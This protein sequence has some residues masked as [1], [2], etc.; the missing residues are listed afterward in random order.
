MHIRKMLFRNTLLFILCSVLCLSLFG[1]EKSYDDKVKD[2]FYKCDS[3]GQFNAITIEFG[4]DI[5]GVY[6]IDGNYGVI[7]DHG[8][9]YL[10]HFFYTP[11]KQRG[12]C[13][14][15]YIATDLSYYQFIA[16]Q[17]HILN[18]FY[19]GELVFCGG[20]EFSDNETVV[21][22]PLDEIYVNEMSIDPDYTV[23]MT[24]TSIPE[25]D[26][27][28]VEVALDN[29]NFV[30]DSYFAFLKDPDTSRFSCEIANLWIDGSTMTGE[31][32]TDGS[33]IPIRMK[34]NEK[35]PYVEI[36]DTSITP[37]KPILKAYARSIDES[38]IELVD[39]N[40]D[41]FYSTPSVSVFITK[42]N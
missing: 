13:I 16:Q 21:T 33:V 39:I 35:V 30:P 29:M 15:L 34:L 18:A 11:R 40:G 4:E 25:E 6:Y 20:C 37:E 14:E 3:D 41:I 7:L 8:S 9:K 36:Y 23:V 28:P 1:C 10:F 17:D 27:V 32:S 2:F 31:W 22:I 42:T 12:G 38:S 26:I 24:K 5:N 19:Y